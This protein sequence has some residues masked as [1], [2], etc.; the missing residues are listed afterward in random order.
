[1]SQERTH[2]SLMSNTSGNCL[3]TIFLIYQEAVVAEVATGEAAAAVVATEAVAA[4]MVAVAAVTVE[5]AAVVAA[6]VVAVE[7]V[8]IFKRNLVTLNVDELLCHRFED[9]F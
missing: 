2:E 1:M 8:C 5:A 6:T 9:F 7:E 3:S 4:A